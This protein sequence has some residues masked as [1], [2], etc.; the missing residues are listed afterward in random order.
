MIKIR[1]TSLPSTL[2]STSEDKIGISLYNAR[3][4]SLTNGSEVK[5]KCGLRQIKVKIQVLP[6]NEQNNSYIYLSSGVYEKILLPKSMDYDVVFKNGT[7]IVGPVIAVL[8]GK[9]LLQRYAKGLKVRES[10]D[11]YSEAGLKSGVLVYFF[12][13]DDIDLTNKSVNGLVRIRDKKGFSYIK[14]QPLP[15][16]DAIHNRLAVAKGS[17]NDK[18][19]I[20]LERSVPDIKIINRITKINKW[21]IYKILSKDKSVSIYLPKTLRLKS[22]KNITDMLQ[23]FPFVILKPVGRSLGL[24]VIKVTKLSSD[25]FKAYYHLNGKNLSI[26]G[27]ID[28]ILDNLKKIMGR[29][30]YIVQ[31]GIELTTFENCPF[32]LRVTMQKDSSADWTLS[33]WYARVA[34]EGSIVTNVSSGGRGVKITKALYPSLGSKTELTLNKIYKASLVICKALDEKI[35]DI[36]D[37]GLDIGIDENGNPYLIEVNFRDFKK[38]NDE[39]GQEEG[40][41]KMYY[42]PIYF[43]KHLYEEK[44]AKDTKD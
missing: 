22:S 4:F 21:K 32:D 26:Q 30:L 20:E 16:P 27:N 35:K 19:L 2:D 5:L 29:R 8:L 9:K 7:F 33:R 1:C 31:Q 28:F 43:L 24:G 41:E 38:Y 37:L 36:G 11:F 39:L 14:R 18:K 12:S 17:I 10:L 25:R 3:K 34:S 44:I 13:L 6:I 42:K 15:V 23:E 40:W